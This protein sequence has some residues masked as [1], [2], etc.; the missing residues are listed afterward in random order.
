M[1]ITDKHEWHIELAEE[2]ASALRDIA[3]Y[4]IGTGVDDWGPISKKLIKQLKAELPLR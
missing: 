2:E 4:C 1:E 3:A